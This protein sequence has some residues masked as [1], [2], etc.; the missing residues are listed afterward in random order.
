M[1]RLQSALP[2]RYT[3]AHPDQLAHWIDDAKQ[4]LGS[5]LLILGHH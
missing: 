3:T 5:R 4:E 1:L 2:E